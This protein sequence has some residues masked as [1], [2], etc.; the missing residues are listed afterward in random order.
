M[1]RRPHACRRLLVT[2]R[3]TH[4]TAVPPPPHAR[5]VICAVRT[6]SSSAAAAAEGASA[7]AATPAF[8]IHTQHGLARTGTLVTPST[9]LRLSTPNCF[10]YSKKGAP[11]H[12]MPDLVREVAGMQAIQ[13][14]IAEFVHSPGETG[15]QKVN[16]RMHEYVR[17]PQHILYMTPRDPLV[18]GLGTANDNGVSVIATQGSTRLSPAQY[19]SLASA[20]EP[21]IVVSLS[22]EIASAVASNRAK[23]SSQRSV[24]WVDDMQNV[25]A[26]KARPGKTL[27]FAAI[28]GGADPIQRQTSCYQLSLRAQAGDAPDAPHA[29]R[30]DGFVLGGLHTGED[31]A[32]HLSLLRS[33]VSSLPPSKP[34][35]LS[36]ATSS[37][38]GAPDQVLRAVEEGVDL[39]EVTY[40]HQLTILGQASVFQM[41]NF[42]ETA[43]SGSSSGVPVTK[44]HLR[45]AKYAHDKQPLLP[46]CTCFTCRNHT[47]AYIHHLLNV[48][49]MLAPV[50]L[51]LHNI[52][53]Y[54]R[55]METIRHHLS[56]TSPRA[57]ADFKSSFLAHFLPSSTTVPLHTEAPVHLNQVGRALL[58]P[59]ASVVAVVE[60]KHGGKE[61]RE[62]QHAAAAVG[63][64]AST[65]GALA[66]RRLL[67]KDNSPL[68]SV[69]RTVLLSYGFTGP[70]YAIHDEELK[71]MW[72][73]Y[74][75]HN[76]PQVTVAPPPAP[77][78]A[79]NPD[80]MED[81][82]PSSAN[83]AVAPAPAL[84]P[85][86]SAY[87]VV[88]PTANDS[89]VLG[90]GGIAPLNGADGSVAELR[91][92]YLLPSIRGRGVGAQVMQLLIERGRAFGFKQ[93][94]LETVETM[95][96][97]MAMYEK[98][99]FKRIQ[100]AMGDTGHHACGVRY[101]LDL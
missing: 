15:M 85:L 101:L 3:A 64:D 66:I 5:L 88:C 99:G 65:V 39:F 91:K 17:L 94:Y 22:D 81:I 55:F 2:V 75:T 31:P 20:Y 9:G 97:A 19:A 73:S 70:G 21:D 89:L 68:E 48:H 44:L 47:R 57:F 24:M 100:H 86:R 60:Q 53:H 67:P 28:Q 41:D 61:G 49:E 26:T 96:E 12:L 56:S 32:M 84:P 16:G 90:G 45:D 18:D 1:L 25:M 50:L 80:A 72:Q 43:A 62:G 42:S 33:I 23:K 63:S 7:A 14:P 54:A 83:T 46:G 59:F 8:T 11:P 78:A 29:K 35:V 87:F 74:E 98:F 95:V 82:A 6:M 76:L 52:H 92:M 38:A 77:S 40:T 37:G 36:A 13:V 27:F 10:F 79:S 69:I 51:D 71:G 58:G 93:I 4:A 34:R 30:I